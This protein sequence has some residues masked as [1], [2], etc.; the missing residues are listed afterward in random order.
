LPATIAS[1]IAQTDHNFAVILGENASPTANMVVNAAQRQLTA[2]G[3]EVRHL[4]APFEMKPVE[5]LNWSHAQSQAAWLKPLFPGEEL[6]REYVA[7]L[8]ERISA[9]PN[10]RVIACACTLDTE[11]GLET[12]AAP[13]TGD[14]ITTTEFKGYFPAH[15]EWL[16][17]TINFAYNRTAWLAL[18]GYSP[19]LPNYAA[20]NLHVLLALHYGVENLSQAL[21]N[22]SGP[23]GF[24]L[25]E[26]RCARVNHS[27]ELWMVLRQAA[28]YCRSAGGPLP[29]KSFFLRAV[30]LALGRR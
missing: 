3:V 14:D 30:A 17:R 22:A 26:N 29:A 4:K 8:K 1:L 13:F 19:Q 21:V 28:I 9:K 23:E 10:A 27:L 24:S 18:G 15:L 6:H 20:L 2:A 12:I 7:R 16:K 11:W 25:N 5:L